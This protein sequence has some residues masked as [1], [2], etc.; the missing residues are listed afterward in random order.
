LSVFQKKWPFNLLIGITAGVGFA[1]L[2]AVTN[3]AIGT[4]NGQFAVMALLML[5]LLAFVYRTELKRQEKVAGDQYREGNNKPHF[6]VSAF[7]PDMRFG[8][9]WPSNRVLPKLRHEQYAQES[10]G[11]NQMVQKAR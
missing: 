1:A 10:N 7:R 3:A 4:E 11:P 8:E 6:E 5:A 9:P 2:I